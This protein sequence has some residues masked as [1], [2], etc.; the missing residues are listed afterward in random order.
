MLQVKQKL[1][2]QTQTYVCEQVHS[3]CLLLNV[4]LSFFIFFIFHA[5]VIYY[6]CSAYTLN[7][8]TLIFITRDWIR[9]TF[10]GSLT[11]LSIT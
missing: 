3:F 11:T 8:L 5:W 1:G 4:K 6:H 10:S 7:M 9:P 2:A